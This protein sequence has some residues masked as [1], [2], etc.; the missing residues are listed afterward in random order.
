MIKRILMNFILALIWVALT[1][2]FLIGNFVFGVILSYGIMWFMY[3]T[4]DD[5]RYFKKIPQTISFLF[6]FFYELWKANL[7][8]AYDVVTPKFHMRPGIVAIPLTAD[9]DLEITLLANVI[10]MTPGTLA[11]DVSD[12]NKYL[13][14]HSMYIKS[15]E[16]FIHSVKNGFERRLLEITR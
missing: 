6:Y 9:T 13:F 14:V 2:K 5:Q 11:L 8:V 12:D 3:R 16:D 4:E 15:K 1:G 10:T 7:L